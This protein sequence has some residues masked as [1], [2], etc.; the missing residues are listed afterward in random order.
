MSEDRKVLGLN[1]LDTIKRSI[2]SAKLSKVAPRGVIDAYTESDVADD[3]RKRLRIKTP[4]VDVGVAKLSGGNQQKVVLAKWLFTDPDL[5]ILDEPTR[6]IDV[7]AKYEIYDHPAARRAGKGV[8]LISSELPELLGISD[9]IYTIFEGRSPM[10]CASRSDPENLM[11]SMTSA[12]ESTAMTTET[13]PSKSN[14]GI[15][16][17]KKMFG[18]GTSSLRQFGILFSLIAI[19]VVFQIWT[20]GTTLSPQNLINVVSQQSYILILAI[21]MVMVIIL[22]H[23]DLSV[24]SVAAFVGIIVAKSMDDWQVPWPVAIGIGLVVGALVGAWQGFWVAYVGV[25]AFIV[26]LAGM[27]IFRGGNQWIGQST[28]T[29]V[30]PE[31]SF[32]G[33]GY[34]PELPIAVNFNVL[35]MLLG[36]IGVGWVFYNEYRL[37]RQQQ[38][39]GVEP[40]PLWVSG[41]KVVPLSARSS[42]RPGCSPP[43]APDE[44]PHLGRD[45]PRPRGGLLVHHEPHRLRSAHYAV[46]GN[47]MAAALSGVKDRRVDFLVMMN[48]SSSPPSPA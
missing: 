19:I 45:P 30:P 22:V 24:G 39:I 43:G 2:V 6:G 12:T 21:G 46:G 10:I 1:L 9:R 11:R 13:V 15:A 5:L 29:P 17:L 42:G 25:P 14:G 33:S 44:L 27:L 4:S 3:Y 48:M 35:T 38:R 31:Y 8:I 16:D 26:T 18:G 34:L 7:G 37:R 36:L 28:T 47:R 32:I 40:A 41:V 20:N 23:I